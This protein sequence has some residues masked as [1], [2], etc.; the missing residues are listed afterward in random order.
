MSELIREV[1][2]VQLIIHDQPDEELKT[3][4]WRW[5][6]FGLH[7]SAL[8]GKHWEHLRACQQEHDLGW[9]CKSAQV[10]KEEQKQQDEEEDHRLPIVYT[11]P[12]LTGPEQIPGALL[13]AM[14]QQLVT[15][16]KELGLVFLDGRIT[17]PPAW[18]QRLKEQVYQSSLLPQNFAGSDD[19]P[20][21]VQTYRQ[22]IGGLADAY[23][24]A[25]H[26]DL[27]YT[28]QC[29][30]H[31]MNLTPGTIDTAI[32]IAIATHDLGKLDAQWQRWARAWQRLL[33]EKGQWSRTYQEYAQS[34]FFAKTDYDYRSDEQRKWQNE[35][36]VKRPKHACES[37]MAA[38]MLIM[39]SLGIDGPDSPNFPVL[40][41]VSGA[42]AH[43]HTPKA[44]EYAA[45]TILAE[46][47]EA[48]KEAFEVVRRD[49]S[50]DY[51]LDHLC[52]TFEKGD[53]FPTNALQGRFTQPD[54][55]SGPDELLETW[56][57]FVV[58]RALRLAD[59]RADRYL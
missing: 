13:I 5:Q 42:I 2:Q 37:V 51:D 54:V 38:R 32:Q 8:M 24:Y 48:I 34:F 15:Y 17:L 10:G 41:A 57:A 59:Q 49:S 27:A 39:H 35:L 33:H 55:A 21:H 25:I 14:P 7:P 45:T 23:H 18:Q 26:H 53:L 58:V 43:H 46:A 9:M 16:D 19:G 31:L 36:S 4:P 1:N 3:R 56:L 11:W 28:M 50:W 22:H 12:P 30:E 29:L 52:L 44:H 40:R 6:S 47:K 20:T